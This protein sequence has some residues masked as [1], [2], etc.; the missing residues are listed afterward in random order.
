MNDAR[1]PAAADSL[2]SDNIA[3]RRH[4][5]AV[6]LV[7]ASSVLNSAGG[8]IVRSLD[9]A[10]QWQMTAWRSLGLGLGLSVIFLFEYRGRV[11]AAIMR[12]GGT[13]IA[14]A[15]ALCVANIT[16]L[17]ALTNTTV[18]NTL[19]VLSAA[20]F[21]TAILALIVLGERVKRVTWIA[22]SVALL[23]L[24]LMFSDGLEAGQLFGN[25]MAVVCALAFSSFVVIMRRGRAVDMLPAVILGSII[26]GALGSTV[27]GFNLAIPLREIVTL[28]L[29][30]FLLSA[31]VHRIFT[32]GSRHVPGA[33]LMLLVLVE[34]ILGP[35]WVWLIFAEEPGKNTLLGGALVIA[36]VAA[37]AISGIRIKRQIP[38]P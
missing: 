27:S 32:F 8:A 9:V 19:F 17:T 33:E 2:N 12:I 37:R 5:L 29:W 16:Y 30:G 7:L 23:G 10:D 22:M 3:A 21:F 4:R 6:I 35:V 20:P 24:G 38:G 14:A 11:G 26:S 15:A 36:A 18:A 34:F 31:L 25:I 28:F 13:G 1:P